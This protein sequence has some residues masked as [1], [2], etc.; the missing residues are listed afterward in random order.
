[1]GLE[2]YQDYGINSFTFVLSLQQDFNCLVNLPK[3]SIMRKSNNVEICFREQDFDGFLK[4]LKQYANIEYIG[5]TVAHNWRQGVIWFYDLDGHI[6]EVGE[7][8]KMVI[9]RFLDSGMTMEK[10]SVKMD[11]SIE[12]LTKLRS[13]WLPAYRADTS[14]T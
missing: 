6:I 3:E 2:T 1:M 5:E 10:A 12:A 7:D 14:L 13:R 8:M 9:N 4:R 11:A